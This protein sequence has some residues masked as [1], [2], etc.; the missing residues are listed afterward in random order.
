[1]DTAVAEMRDWDETPYDG[2]YA[3]LHALADREFTGAVE[4]AGAWLFMLRGRVVGVF[5][6]Q[7]TETGETAF[8]TADI[9]RFEDATGAARAAPH[10]ALPLLYAMRA[11]G[12][13]ERGRYYTEDTPLAEVHERLSAGGFTGYVELSE[14]VLSGDYYLVY[15]GGRSKQVAFVGQSRRLLE[16]DEAFERA[17]DEVGIY[18]VTAVDLDITEIPGEP[19]HS[20]AAAGAAGAAGAASGAGDTQVFDGRGDDEPDRAAA[21]GESESTAVT[22]DTAITDETTA[23]GD[24]DEAGAEGTDATEEI[25]AVGALE[26]AGGSDG[27]TAEPTAEATGTPRPDTGPDPATDGEPSP[28]PRDTGT[29]E[30]V[31]RAITAIADTTDD[32]APAPNATGGEATSAVASAGAEPEGD[33][34]GVD[35]ATPIEATD[36]GD[37]GTASQTGEP[38]A[39]STAGAAVPAA[40]V[41]ALRE[42]LADREAE[43]ERL[44]DELQSTRDERDELRARVEDLEG[45]LR[46]LGSG[47]AAPDR[48]IP[49]EEALAG[50]SLFVR[51]ESRSAPTLAD[52]QQGAGREGVVG[53]LRLDPHAEF[54]ADAV[55]VGGQAFDAFLEGTHEYRFARWLVTDLPLEIRDTGSAESVG[56]LYEAIPDIDRVVFDTTVSVADREDPRFDV[57]ARDRKGNP[58]V[59]AMLGESR[60]PVQR[61]ELAT[62]VTDAT[63]VCEKRSSLVGAMSVTTAFFEPGALETAEQATSKSLLSRDRRES[64]VKRSRSRG[65][66]LCLVE[67]RE[68]SFYLSVPDL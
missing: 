53:N 48:S 50:A 47:A 38:E 5:D 28:A 63:A 60:E 64:F 52:L 24:G 40:E 21:E 16:D 51:Y 13:E 43:I 27:E 29:G 31:R 10:A 15:H 1:M 54:D 22:A 6:Q 23:A 58:L 66:H 18:T 36:D 44:E 8:V 20:G 9:E 33:E 12:G 65:F 45:R 7:E 17:D 2:G 59:V 32:A 26:S 67:S 46:E 42:T 35:A 34:V 39:E 57:V 61:D 11:S 55:A 4:A 30:S 25:D 3:G 62:F 56:A 68:D 19:D 41:A 37:A 49:P 14:N